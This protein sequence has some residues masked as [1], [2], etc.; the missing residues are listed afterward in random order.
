M[1]ATMTKPN[2]W[3][4]GPWIVGTDTFDNDGIEESLIAQRNGPHAIAFAIEISAASSDTRKANA[5]LIASAPELYEAL[6]EL[7]DSMGCNERLPCNVCAKAR[8]ALS[9][10]EGG[11]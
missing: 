10:A 8:A 11:V 2:G 6:K 4:G 5:R 1:T 9:A 7:V 3:T